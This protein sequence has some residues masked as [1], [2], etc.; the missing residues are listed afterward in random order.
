MTWSKRELRSSD[1]CAKFLHGDCITDICPVQSGN[2]CLV[3]HKLN[4]DTVAVVIVIIISY[5]IHLCS[6]LIIRLALIFILTPTIFFSLLCQD[7]NVPW[8][9]YGNYEYNPGIC[10]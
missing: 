1:T 2:S 7:Y 5:I 4:I 10:F 3:Q 9:I 6:I 8:H